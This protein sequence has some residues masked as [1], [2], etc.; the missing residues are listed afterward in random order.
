VPLHEMECDRT[1][2]GSHPRHRP[3]GLRFGTHGQV[4]HDL[5]A[6]T[7]NMDMRGVV[8]AWRQIDEDAEPPLAK[9][10]RHST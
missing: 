8:L 10:G 2:R 1:V 7:P 5:A 6:R 3:N 4:D 9:H